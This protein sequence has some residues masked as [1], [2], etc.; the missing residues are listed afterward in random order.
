MNPLYPVAPDPFIIDR[1]TGMMRPHDPERDWATHIT[2]PYERWW[3][4][5]CGFA[6]KPGGRYDDTDP[7]HFEDNWPPDERARAQADWRLRR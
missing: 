3:C 1:K 5:R 6:I 2:E 7:I 4:R